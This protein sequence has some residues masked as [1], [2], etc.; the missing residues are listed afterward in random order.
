MEKVNWGVLGTAGIAQGQTIPGMMEA[1]ACFK[2]IYAEQ[3]A[4]ARAHTRR[5][6]I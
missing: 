1:P 5:D 2:G 3:S 6:R 4:H